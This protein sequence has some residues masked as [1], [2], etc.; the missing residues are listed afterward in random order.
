M[1]II[2]GFSAPFLSDGEVPSTIFFWLGFLLFLWPGKYLSK[3]SSWIKWARIGL[4]I[5]VLG[6]LAMVLLVYTAT[7][8][9]FLSGYFVFLILKVSSSLLH[10]ISTV[11][12]L[13]VPN[14]QFKMPDGSFL[15][16]T[17]FIRAS[18]LSFC[19]ILACILISVIAGKCISLWP[20]KGQQQIKGSYE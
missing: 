7:H 5:H 12:D 17:G 19:N 11:F 4:T 18:V 8:A 9:S 6:T 14:E 2:G 20:N 10:P 16:R 13:L 1:V 15:I 3:K